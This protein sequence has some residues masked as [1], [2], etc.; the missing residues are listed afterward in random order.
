MNIDPQFGICKRCGAINRMPPGFTPEYFR[1]G[2]CG[3]TELKL[4]ESKSKHASKIIAS[5]VAGAGIG[6]VFGGGAGAAIGGFIGFLAGSIG[7]S[8]TS[9]SGS[10]GSDGSDGQ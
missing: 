8:G 9:T 5:S 4:A 7:T 1:C 10:D 6:A 2:R 3:F